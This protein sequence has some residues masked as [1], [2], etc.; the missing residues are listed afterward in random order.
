MYTLKKEYADNKVD[1]I[2]SIFDSAI[3]VQK[4]IKADE[5]E[6]ERSS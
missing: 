4:E 5:E 1:L 3:E 6:K 2:A